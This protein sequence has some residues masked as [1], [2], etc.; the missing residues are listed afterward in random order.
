[1]LDPAL[2]TLTQRQVIGTMFGFLSKD[3]ERPF[4]QNVA[5]SECSETSVDSHVPIGRRWH[6]VWVFIQEL[7][8]N[9]LLP[10]DELGLS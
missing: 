5:P 8:V 6:D 10:P 1:V 3:S 2:R 9:E 4:P 7:H